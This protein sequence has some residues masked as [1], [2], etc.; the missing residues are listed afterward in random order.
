MGLELGEDNNEVVNGREEESIHE[1][2]VSNDEVEI[3]NH[4]FD[5]V[6]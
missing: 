2:E 4:V 1:L 3:V 6:V 5:E